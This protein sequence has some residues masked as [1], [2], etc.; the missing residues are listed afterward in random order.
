MQRRPP[1]STRTDTCIPFTTLFRSPQREGRMP[2]APAISAD[3][4]EQAAH[5]LMA[6]AGIEIPDDYL[7]GIRAMAGSE[8]GDLS[9]FVLRSLL[10]NRSEEH[11][12]ELQSLLRC[13]Y[14]VFWFKKNNTKFK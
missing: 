8:R 13:S 3:L 2:H 5:T 1:G 12:S 10:E 14:A 7:G 4:L 6:K 11:T 9:A